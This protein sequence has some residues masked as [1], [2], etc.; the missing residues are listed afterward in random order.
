M[1]KDETK[2]LCQWCGKVNYDKHH[3]SGTD[4]YIKGF[5]DGKNNTPCEK[6]DYA[7][8]LREENL[9]MKGGRTN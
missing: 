9:K 8:M 1:V 2:R 7:L 4:A 5:K 6:L 3:C